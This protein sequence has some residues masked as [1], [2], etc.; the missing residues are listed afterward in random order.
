[1]H[2]AFTKI[3]HYQYSKRNTKKAIEMYTIALDKGDSEAAN[4]L[5]LIYESQE[6]RDLDKA[7]QFYERAIALDGNIDAYFNFGILLSENN[8]NKEGQALI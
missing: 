2:K 5:G 1:M 4:C 7:Q 6:F 3:A 8:N